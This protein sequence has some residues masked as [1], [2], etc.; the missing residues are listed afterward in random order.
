MITG[1]VPGAAPVLA[2]ASIACGLLLAGARTS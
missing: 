2:T 1:F